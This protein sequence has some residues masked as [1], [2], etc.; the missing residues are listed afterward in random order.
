LFQE[1]QVGGQPVLSE[2]KIES[3]EHSKERPKYVW[4]YFLLAPG[5]YYLSQ[6]LTEALFW[7]PKEV[8]ADQLSIPE[9]VKNYASAVIN[10]YQLNPEMYHFVVSGES[11][12]NPNAVGDNGKARNVMQYWEKTFLRHRERAGMLEA[13]Y[14][15]WRSQ[16][17]VSA[18]IFKNGTEQERREWT[19]Y[20]RFVA[21]WKTCQ[22]F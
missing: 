14:N 16:L 6:V 22:K 11:G 12:Y 18:W 21:G 3:L 9:A 4:R 19:C 10:T 13:K 20:R 8:K 17:N 5:E 1:F 2:I 7:K 15:D